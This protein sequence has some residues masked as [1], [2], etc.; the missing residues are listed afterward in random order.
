VLSLS[1]SRP[2][3]DTR[4]HQTR[5]KSPG[6]RSITAVASTGPG[7]HQVRTGSFRRSELS[8]RVDCC[9][10]DPRLIQDLRT[11]YRH[12]HTRH[13]ASLL[14]PRTNSI[15]RSKHRWLGHSRS[16]PA[17]V[18]PTRLVRTCRYQPLRRT[19]LIRLGSTRLVN[20]L[21]MVFGRR[22]SSIRTLCISS[23]LTPYRIPPSNPTLTLL[24]SASPS[25]PISLSSRTSS[26]PTQPQSTR[27]SSTPSCPPQPSPS[28]RTY[29][30]SRL[31]LC[32][33]AHTSRL[34]IPTWK[35]P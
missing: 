5:T 3:Q 8:G 13:P 26:P 1:G 29:T 6:V 28:T 33:R 7:D 20:K 34:H 21:W 2:R 27:I 16:R 22:W 9:R 35:A 4:R 10:G 11:N 30:N 18:R 12:L 31:S 15:S 14:H 23:V 19:S 32:D 25:L 17:F 24:V